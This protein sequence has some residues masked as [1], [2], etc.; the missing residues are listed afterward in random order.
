MFSNGIMLLTLAAIAL[1]VIFG[2]VTTRLIP[3]YAI[4]VFTSFT[5]SQTGMIVHHLREQGA[6]LAAG[7]WR[8]TP[9]GAA[10]TA[11][12]R[13][14][15]ATAKFADGRV[16][17]AHPHPGDR[18]VLPVGEAPVRRA[19]AR[20]LALDA[21]RAHR[22]QL[23]VVQPNAQPRDRAGEGHRPPAGRALQ[24]AK[25]LQAD[26]VEAVYV[27]ISGK[28]AKVQAPVG[29]GRVR[30]PADGHRVAVPRDHRRRSSTTS[31][32][33]PRP[34]CDHVV[35]VIL[36][37]YAA[38]NPADQ[39]LHDQTS[40]WLKQQLFGEPGVILTDVPVPHRRA[41]AASRCRLHATRALPSRGT[42]G[43]SVATLS[44]GDS[45]RLVDDVSSSAPSD[46]QQELV[47]GDQRVSPRG[48]CT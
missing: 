9:F 28:A 12:V 32:P 35:T 39:M 41:A 21:R 16:D 10:T 25:S 14:V 3:L 19:C 5:L 1:L 48:A 18:L 27:D 26:K 30:H 17:R 11:L 4:G 2:G 24:Y 42:P 20:E 15:I 37:E 8:S 36:P 34:T 43:V 40:F 13:V 45:E 22:P 23:A 29:R 46:E 7:R 31:A 44:L 38:E 47:A 6:E 33:I